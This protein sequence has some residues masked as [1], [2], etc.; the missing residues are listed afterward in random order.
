M[1]QK[2]KKHVLTFEEEFPFQVLGVIS[3]H[4]EYRL[5]WAINNELGYRLEAIEPLV[6]IDKK[7]KVTTEHPR[8]LWE[9]EENRITFHLIR[10]K[11]ANKVLFPERPSIDYLM[12][13]VS[14][15]DHDFELDD[16][17]K[18][19]KTIDSILGAYEF[20][21]EELETLEILDI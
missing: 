7:S 8:Y 18:K 15:E 2:K 19:L 9:D 1:A 5:V 3:S 12:V 21:P 20:D 10:N 13:V 16:L 4:P 6:S 11:V 14:G 17:I